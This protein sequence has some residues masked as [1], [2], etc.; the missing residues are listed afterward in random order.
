MPKVTTK[1]ILLCS[2]A[3]ILQTTNIKLKIMP[4]TKLNVILNEHGLR[5]ADKQPF[6]EK[7]MYLTVDCLMLVE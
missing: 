4:E 3:L 1:A 6:P 2:G 5:L 7:K